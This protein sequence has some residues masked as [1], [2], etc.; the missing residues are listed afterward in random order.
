MSNRTCYGVLVRVQYATPLSSDTH[1]AVV[2]GHTLCCL[3][4]KKQ[5]CY[6]PKCLPVKGKA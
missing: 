1:Y 4:Q 3:C 6:I 5:Q 2:K